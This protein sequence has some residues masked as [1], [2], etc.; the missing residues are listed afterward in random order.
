[1]KIKLMMEDVMRKFLKKSQENIILDHQAE[2]ERAKDQGMLK[3]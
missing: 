3:G 1:M 2:V